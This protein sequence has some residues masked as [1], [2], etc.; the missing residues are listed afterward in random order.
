M[1]GL[2]FE[3]SMPGERFSLLNARSFFSLDSL[4]LA[5]GEVESRAM[6]YVC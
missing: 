6:N 3:E 5:I 1:F 2:R 4:L